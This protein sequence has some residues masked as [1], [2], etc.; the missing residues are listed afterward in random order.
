MVY[1]MTIYANGGAWG[2]NGQ[3]D[4]VGAAA[5]VFYLRSWHH[6]AWAMPLPDR[7][8]PTSERTELTAIALALEQ[9]LEKSS[10]LRNEPLLDIE[11]HSDSEYVITCM[12]GPIYALRLSQ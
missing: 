1:K 12:N 2:R 8:V 4:A 9:A 11:I 10:H 5:V 6:Q 3:A 7:H